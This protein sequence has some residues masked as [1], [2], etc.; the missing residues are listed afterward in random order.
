MQATEAHAPFYWDGTKA[1]R[2]LTTADKGLIVG[3]GFP[4]YSTGVQISGSSYT[5]TYKCW[6]I[7]TTLVSTL[8]P[9]ELYVNGHIVGKEEGDYIDVQMPIDVGDVVTVSGGSFNKLFVYAIKGAN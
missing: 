4:D 6:L 1:F 9:Q 5:A 3:W 2:L 8:T 7:G